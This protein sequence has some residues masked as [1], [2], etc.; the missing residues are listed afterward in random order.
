M[1]AAQALA[2]DLARRSPSVMRVTKKQVLRWE[3]SNLSAAQLHALEL[4]E[5]A[6]AFS[7]EDLAQALATHRARRGANH[8]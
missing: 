8:E 1:F 2:A 7:S 5:M 3:Q 6:D 4:L